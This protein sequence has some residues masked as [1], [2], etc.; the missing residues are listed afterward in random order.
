MRKYI[1]LSAP[2]RQSDQ[3]F[4]CF[5]G[6]TKGLPVTNKQINNNSN[7]NCLTGD[8][9]DLRIVLLG[10][11]GAG[12]SSTGNAILGRD[13][14][15]ESRTR[16]SEIQRGRVKDRNISIIDT[17][18]FFNTHLTDEE[19][20]KQMMKSLDLADPGPHVFLLIINLENFEEDERNVVEQIQENFGAQVFKFT[21]VLFI[22]REQMSKKEWML[23]MLCTKFQELVSDFRDN[24]HAINSKNE[25]NQTHIS[26]LLEK[27]DEFIKQNN[28]QV[29]NTKI[30]SMSRTKSIRIKKKQEEKKTHRRK[31][32]EIKQKQAKTAYETFTI[33]SVKKEK[34][35]HAVI[36]Q[37]KE[38]KENTYREK[39][40]E[41]RQEQAKKKSETFEMES[42]MEKRKTHSVA[43]EQKKSFISYVRQTNE[44]YHMCENVDNQSLYRYEEF[45]NEKNRDKN[46]KTSEKYWR[47]RNK[48]T[49]QILSKDGKNFTQNPKH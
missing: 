3:L 48:E 13:V 10:V 37:V 38:R 1:E 30:Y 44:S 16:E 2:F 15:K 19:M 25:M 35:T 9:Q 11:S 22:G 21:L 20:K 42:E 27:I 23:F 33:H 8:S 7:L 17:P 6:H 45:S 26:E 39:K 49:Y 5:G 47:M 28:H 32:Q 46:V 43:K 41:E 24:Y 18:G 12:K 40:Q 29:Y 4:V 34:T 36:E 31:E 14:F